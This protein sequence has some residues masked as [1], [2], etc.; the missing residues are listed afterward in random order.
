M[1]TEVK[2][3]RKVSA[4]LY[5]GIIRVISEKVCGLALPLRTK[6]FFSSIKKPQKA[7]IISIIKGMIIQAIQKITS[8]IILFRSISIPI[9]ET[10]YLLPYDMRTGKYIKVESN[11]NRIKKYSAKNS[12]SEIEN[13]ITV[14]VNQCAN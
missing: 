2:Q 10:T 1:W 5:I 13:L 8:L 9:I 7:G 11:R 3:V 4:E 12:M 14:K 6:L